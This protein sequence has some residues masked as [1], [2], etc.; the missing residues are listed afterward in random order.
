MYAVIDPNWGEP[1][2]MPETLHPTQEGAQALA[3]VSRN[4]SLYSGATLNCRPQVPGEWGRL[5]RFGY[6]AA[7]IRAEIET[8]D[9]YEPTPFA[10][11]ER[12]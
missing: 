3:T 10:A 12:G 5:E 11:Y 6:R 4:C 9:G 7:K 2:I 8:D 1:L